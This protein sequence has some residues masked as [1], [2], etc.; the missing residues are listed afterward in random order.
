[1]LRH[2]ELGPIADLILELHQWLSLFDPTSL[3][4]LDY[5]GLCNLLTWDEMDD[6]HSAREVAEALRA[7]SAEEYARSAEL[8]Q[9]ALG[10]SNEL[11]NRE[12]SN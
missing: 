3:L 4:E 6:D 8:Y 5:G 10:R 11:R 1:V 2:T 12:T 9:A 7:L